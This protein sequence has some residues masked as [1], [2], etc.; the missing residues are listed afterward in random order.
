MVLRLFKID[1]DQA[2][3]STGVIFP[4][5]GTD[6]DMDIDC[7][8]FTHCKDSLAKLKI[9]WISRHKQYWTIHVYNLCATEVYTT[10]PEVFD[11]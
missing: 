10:L 5:Y 2:S 8:L 9:F 7:K 4:M 3:T 11:D 1:A 6:I